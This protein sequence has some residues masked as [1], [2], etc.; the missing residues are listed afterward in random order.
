M[1]LRVQLT[2]CVEMSVETKCYAQHPAGAS[3]VQGDGAHGGL[4]P[5][6][7]F[8]ASAKRRQFTEPDDKLQGTEQRLAIKSKFYLY[9]VLDY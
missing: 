7:G 9:T 3:G 5:Q 2:A 6:S 4:S 1:K 8:L